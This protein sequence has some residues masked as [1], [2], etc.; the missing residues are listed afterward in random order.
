MEG[1]RIKEG[2]NLIWS[3]YLFF[4]P[5]KETHISGNLSGRGDGGVQL[6]EEG[7]EQIDGR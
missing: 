4:N 6:Q 2:C 1:L 5:L 7:D 3:V